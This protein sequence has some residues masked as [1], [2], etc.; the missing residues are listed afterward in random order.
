VTKPSE[1]AP[2]LSIIVVSLTS[3]EQ[4]LN[5][6]QQLRE[7]NVL[8]SSP[9][10]TSE[11]IVVDLVGTEAESC[12]FES[13]FPCVTVLTEASDIGFA[14]ATNLGIAAAQAEHILLI[15][16]F[17]EIPGRL[18]P[19]MVL[20]LDTNE[21]VAAVGPQLIDSQGSAIVPAASGAP[22]RGEPNGAAIPGGPPQG[23]TTSMRAVE[24]LPAT[25]LMLNR[26]ALEEIG[27]L[28]EVFLQQFEEIDWCRRAREALWNIH[29]L[30]SVSVVLLDDHSQLNGDGDAAGEAPY[31]G[32]FSGSRRAYLRQ[33]PGSAAA[34]AVGAVKNSTHKLVQ[35]AK[36]AIGLASEG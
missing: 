17:T 31:D 2:T 25:C 26:S 23:V 20:H 14:R 32:Q 6:L 7:S 18:V 21:R 19:D 13:N 35:S 28:E 8:S 24:W 11:V 10:G 30:D 29:H 12:E 36:V 34:V 1:G 33:H 9:G 22:E 4:T 15:D 27:G 16:P 3:R 5:C